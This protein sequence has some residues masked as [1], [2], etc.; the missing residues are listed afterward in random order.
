MAARIPTIT[1]LTDYG[2][3]D[4]FVSSMKGV[5]YS[6]AP[7]VHIVDISHD[8]PPQDL[9]EAAFLIRNCYSYFPIRSIHVVVVDPTVG[10]ARKPIIVATDN[11]Y[12]VAPDNGVLSFI[13][14]I[15]PVST[16]VEITA[17]HHMLSSISKTFHGRDIFAPAAAWLARGIDILNF[18][19]TQEEYVRLAVP[20]AKLVGESL[21]KGVV[22]HVDRFGNLIT[23]ISREEF[24]AAREKVPG[25]SCKILI[26]KQE[27]TGLKEYYAEAK[28]GELIALFGS[29]N[30][31]EIAQ[32]QGSAA[33]TLGAGRGTEAGILLK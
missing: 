26:T 21:I 5:I 18:G 29:T 19:D 10:S 1:L 20:K 2:T 17:E 14:D 28:P 24:D 16:V 4:H 32:N 11:H 13:Y 15:E 7:E 3:R 22:V 6:I 9:M 33:K 31:L 12:F 27:I 30:L 23:N 8:V 25:Q